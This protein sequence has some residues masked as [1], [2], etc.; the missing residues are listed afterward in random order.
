MPPFSFKKA[1]E[2]ASL[3]DKEIERFAIMYMIMAEEIKPTSKQY[4][5][6]A[7]EADNTVA[8][9]KILFSTTLKKLREKNC[10]FEDRAEGEDGVADAASVPTTPK[11]P[12]RR[13]RPKRKVDDGDA[14]PKKKPRGKKGDDGALEDAEGEAGLTATEDS[15]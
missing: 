6:A 7:G 10:Y 9:F 13:G 2:T 1:K 12:G 4:E 3:N 5:L 8:S 14:S 11:T 15:V